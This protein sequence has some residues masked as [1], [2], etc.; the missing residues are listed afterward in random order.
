MACLT[1]VVVP[2]RRILKSLIYSGDNLQVLQ[3]R[4]PRH[5]TVPAAV[6]AELEFTRT[7]DYMVNVLCMNREE[8]MWENLTEFFDIDVLQTSKG[9][10]GKQTNR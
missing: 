9:F 1:V 4:C 3:L 2:S 6:A 7:L 8:K 10:K 5:K